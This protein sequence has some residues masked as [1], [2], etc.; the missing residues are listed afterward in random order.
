M[1]LAQQKARLAPDNNPGC[2]NSFV[3]TTADF[4]RTSGK[5]Q[6]SVTYAP[7]RS[8]YHWELTGRS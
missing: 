6:F 2:V 5:L 3:R 1:L 8:T 7:L 4:S